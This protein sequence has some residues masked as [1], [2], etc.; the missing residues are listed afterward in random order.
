M[1][2]AYFAV[3]QPR[4][5]LPLQNDGEPA[6]LYCWIFLLI[7]ILGPGPFALDTLL[8]RPRRE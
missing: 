4:G 3:H 1:A 7:A 6:A 5:L 2:F 8:R